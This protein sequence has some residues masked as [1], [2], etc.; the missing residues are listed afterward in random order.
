[1]T[2]KKIDLK[3]RAN[4]I[5]QEI[6]IVLPGTQALLGF[7]LVIFFNP[8]FQSLPSHQKN[9]HFVTLLITAAATILLMAPVAFQQLGDNGNVTARFISFARAM[10]HAAM[11]LLLIGLA[12]DIYIAGKVIEFS[13]TLAILISA[14]TFLAGFS[15]W[16]VYVLVRRKST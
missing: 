10:I 3:S 13:D 4:Q 6:R 9:L 7:Q 8:V 11:L 16:Y 15:L 1:M 5:L 14:S 2:D 12:G